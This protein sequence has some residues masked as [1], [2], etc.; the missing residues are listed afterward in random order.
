MLTVRQVDARRERIEQRYGTRKQL[1]YR[2]ALIGL[3]LEER[4]ALADLKDLDFLEGR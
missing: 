1:E 4:T 3:T 2:L